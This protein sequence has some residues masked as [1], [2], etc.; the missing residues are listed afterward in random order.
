MTTV[1]PLTSGARRGLPPP[2]VACVFW[3][4]DRITTDE[5]RKEDWADSFERRHGAFQQF[6][7]PLPRVAFG[8][9]AL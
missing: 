1:S 2:C 8:Q 5:R 6:D 7:A 3:Q 9:P 4:H